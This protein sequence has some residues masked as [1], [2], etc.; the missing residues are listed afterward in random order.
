[1][2]KLTFYLSLLFP[3]LTYSQIQNSN[4]E[5]IADF[6]D[7]SSK[8][9][10]FNGGQINVQFR[11]TELKRNWIDSSNEKI[12]N[13][14]SPLK[15]AEKIEGLFFDFGLVNTTNFTDLDAIDWKKIGY[16]FGITWQHS[17]SK[18]YFD[19]DYNNIK[20]PYLST[21]NISINGTFDRF[22]NFDPETNKIDN[23]MPF[24]G[25]VSANYS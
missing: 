13:I 1:M 23:V 11:L 17:F 22:N 4:K 16:K 19:K 7:A 8:R 3:I 14:E 24:R 20:H 21:W 25:G 10:T 18:V 15:T 9:L 6:Y 5:Q 12:D 2:R